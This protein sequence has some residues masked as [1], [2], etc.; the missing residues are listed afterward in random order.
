MG[1][2]FSKIP[3]SSLKY[4]VLVWNNWNVSESFFYEVIFKKIVGFPILLP[5]VS[6][7]QFSSPFSIVSCD[8]GFQSH[9][10]GLVTW[11][12]SQ[13][14]RRVQYPII[15]KSILERRRRFK[16]KSIARQKVTPPIFIRIQPPSTKIPKTEIT[17]KCSF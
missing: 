12:L 11:R 15:L 13:D 14:N 17:G 5:P 16:K 1:L 10:F 6:G 2:R 7:L 8:R 3:R 4:S 9:L